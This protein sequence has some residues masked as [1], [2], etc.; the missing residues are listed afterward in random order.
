LTEALK[1]D[2]PSKLYWTPAMQH[3][4]QAIKASLLWATVPILYTWIHKLR[5]AWELMSPPPTSELLFS[6]RRGPLGSLGLL[7]KIMG[8]W[9][10]EVIFL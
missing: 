9:L 2:K 3:G 5:S 6:R 8:F 1:G 4:S 7:Q 10:V